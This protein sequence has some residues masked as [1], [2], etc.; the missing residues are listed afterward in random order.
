MLRRPSRLTGFQHRGRLTSKG[1][2]RAADTPANEQHTAGDR[3][4]AGG[5]DELQRVPELVAK[6]EDIIVFHIAQ[7][8]QHYEEPTQSARY[9]KAKM[10]TFSN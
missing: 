7:A 9:W 2:P 10:G 5:A 6:A 4:M 3:V 1:W 8:S